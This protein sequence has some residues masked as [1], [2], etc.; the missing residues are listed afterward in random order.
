MKEE[1][2]ADE[3]KGEKEKIMAPEKYCAMAM[4]ISNQFALVN[5]H[6]LQKLQ[7][8]EQGA[9]FFKFLLQID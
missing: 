1:K 5:H 6:K 8:I 7:S 4:L 2:S 3:E 9:R